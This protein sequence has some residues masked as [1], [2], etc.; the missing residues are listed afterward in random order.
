MIFEKGNNTDSGNEDDLIR[1]F[2]N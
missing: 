2:D 1:E